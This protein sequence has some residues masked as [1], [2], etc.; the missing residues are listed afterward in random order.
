MRLTPIYYFMRYPLCKIPLRHIGLPIVVY[1]VNV[2]VFG[3]HFRR[4]QTPR[5]RM[6]I[7]WEAKG[8]DQ[9]PI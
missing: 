6:V 2:K 5:G 7:V 8:A 3:A 4:E 1:H 9:P